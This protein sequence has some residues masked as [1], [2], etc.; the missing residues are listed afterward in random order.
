MADTLDMI[1]PG[2]KFSIC[3]LVKL[4]DQLATAKVQWWDREKMIVIG[5]LIP[6]REYMEGRKESPGQSNLKIQQGT[7]H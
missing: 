6:K 7:F 3:G 2:A 5:I 1:H 4:G